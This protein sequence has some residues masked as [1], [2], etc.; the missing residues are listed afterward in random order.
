MSKI[1]R[2]KY[3]VDLFI[4]EDN[5]P[6]DIQKYILIKKSD[7]VFDGFHPNGKDEGYT[8]IGT[9]NK[10]PTV[11]ERFIIRGRRLTEYLNTS[12]VTEIVSDTVFKT[13][14]STYELTEYNGKLES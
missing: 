2:D 7:D 11:G 13:E 12:P 1:E 14:N 4:P 6:K 8:I 5:S 3:N 9:F 10:A